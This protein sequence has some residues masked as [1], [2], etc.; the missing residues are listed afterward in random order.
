[1]RTQTSAG[2][3]KAEKCRPLRA[4]PE[5]TTQRTSAQLVHWGLCIFEWYYVIFLMKIQAFSLWT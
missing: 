3:F 2:A 1:M 5:H 4:S